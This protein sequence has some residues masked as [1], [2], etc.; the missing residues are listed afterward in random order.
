MARPDWAARA[1]ETASS[2]SELA[3]APTILA[4]GPVHFDDPDARGLEVPAEPGPV[5]PRPFDPDEAHFAERA[6]P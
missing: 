2:G 5:A 1:A 3:L 6:Q 4:I